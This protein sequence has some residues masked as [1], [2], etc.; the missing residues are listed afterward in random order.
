MICECS[1]RS[2][3][4]IFGLTAKPFLST[5]SSGDLIGMRFLPLDTCSSVLSKDYSLDAYV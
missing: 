1:H 5:L 3:I 4:L 2:K